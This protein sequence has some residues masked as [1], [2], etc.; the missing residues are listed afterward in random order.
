MQSKNLIE[1][2]IPVLHDPATHIRL[3]EV[4]ECGGAT[5]KVTIHVL[6]TTV[7][8]A[9]APTYHAVSYTW[10]DPS[11]QESVKITNGS[12][13]PRGNT[14]EHVIS[15][16]KNCADVLRQLLHFKTTKYYW[17][18]A[19]CIDQSNN[20]EKSFQV[21]MMGSIFERAERVLCCLGTHQDDSKYM[22]GIL[23]D[24][25]KYLT[26]YNR[27]TAVFLNRGDWTDDHGWTLGLSEHWLE[28]VSDTSTL[29]LFK[30]LDAFAERSYFWRI[31]IL[32][33]IFLARQLSFLC[34]FD[35]IFIP[36][37]LFWWD[38]AKLQ[39]F[40]QRRDD[41]AAGHEP[42]ILL[43]K[44]SATEDGEDFLSRARWND[45]EFCL[46]YGA[47]G[48][49]YEFQVALRERA[50]PFNDSYKRQ[51]IY[52]DKLL[53]LCES[54]DCKDPRDTIYGTLALSDWGKGGIVAPGGQIFSIARLDDNDNDS[55]D[56]KLRPDYEIS[57]YN[58]ARVILQ[59]L[60]I[61]NDLVKLIIHMLKLE[62]SDPQVRAGVDSR[63]H[64]NDPINFDE[65]D[66]VIIL[67]WQS[68]QQQ[69]QLVEGGFQLTTESG[70]VIEQNSALD[71]VHIHLADHLDGPYA[72]ASATTKLNDWIVPTMYN[73]GFVLR[74]IKAENRFFAIVGKVWFPA[75]LLP[76]NLQL[77]GFMLWLGFD[78][79][80]V[81]LAGGL[82]PLLSLDH[83][84]EDD[85]TTLNDAVCLQRYS[86]FAEIPGIMRSWEVPK[87][88][89]ACRA[90]TMRLIADWHRAWADRHERKA[91]T[92]PRLFEG[93]PPD[94]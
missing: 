21:A 58:L 59:H 69:L 20:H 75:G 25:D 93:K 44:L 81:H 33:E 24:F 30:A 3:L 23:H 45:T 31:W 71:N 89:D 43:R 92:D 62:P 34:E 5:D 84:S 74:H 38:D 79:L 16:H 56:E 94:L 64:L 83:P 46:D 18:D 76:N 36:T 35:E 29:R 63:H 2:T 72:T 41:R 78:D 68:D 65:S 73:Y 85:L 8:F 9:E 70:W 49:G 1:S 28:N 86:S 87:S 61:T 11:Q 60:N 55:Q 66:D 10:G 54:R 88:V 32:Q 42:P 48:L 15:V 17:I 67:A 6:L 91:L 4:S 27:S 80:L 47:S 19:I 14:R 37:L 22:V 13:E 7:L 40:F 77:T 90:E 50:L 39:W 12:S 26:S 82:C 52:Q 53:M 51:E 57:V